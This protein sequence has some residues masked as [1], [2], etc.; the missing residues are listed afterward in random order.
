M[1]RII[2]FLLLISAG[3]VLADAGNTSGSAQL[4]MALTRVQQEQQA[5]YQQFQMIQE[6]RRSDM[7][8]GYRPGAP[9]SPA[10]MQALPSINYD[11]SVAQQ[12]QQQERIEQRTHEMNSLYAR[13]VELGRQR[14]ALLDQI[15]N[16]AMPPKSR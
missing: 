12:R 6:L 2:F 4:E 13:Y 8:S 1:R 15:I 11:E 3:V 9:P 7:E 5:V 14:Q 10:N 16:L